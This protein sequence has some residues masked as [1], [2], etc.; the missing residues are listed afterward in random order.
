MSEPD[1]AEFEQDLK[2]ATERELDALDA[3]SE[4]IGLEGDVPRP[5]SRLCASSRER[6]AGSRTGEGREGPPKQAT[7]FAVKPAATVRRPRDVGPGDN[8]EQEGNSDR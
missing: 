6:A 4:R 3:W 1:F 5:L 7:Y 8:Q 2:R